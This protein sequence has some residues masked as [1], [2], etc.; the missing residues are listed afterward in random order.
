MVGIADNQDT[1][2][3][4][5]FWCF[6]ILIV[7]FSVGDGLIEDTRFNGPAKDGAKYTD[8]GIYTITVQNE[9]TNQIT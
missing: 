3:K 2:T 7:T 6:K 5:H 1:P 9:Y 4:V 8:D